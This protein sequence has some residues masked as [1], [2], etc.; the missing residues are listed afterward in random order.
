M[1][2]GENAGYLHFLLSHNVLKRPHIRVT[3]INSDTGHFSLRFL[4]F[5]MM[6]NVSILLLK[7]C[8]TVIRILFNPLPHNATF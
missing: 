2:K 3:G 4:T 7:E 5:G 1:G 8:C 6:S